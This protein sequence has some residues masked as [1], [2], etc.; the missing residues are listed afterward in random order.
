V[1]FLNIWNHTNPK[2]TN[3]T[4]SINTNAGMSWGPANV[5]VISGA[6]WAIIAATIR[7]DRFDEH[8]AISPQMKYAEYGSTSHSAGGVSK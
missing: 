6:K 7:T 3:V 4:K 2:A 8:A 1:S 5:K